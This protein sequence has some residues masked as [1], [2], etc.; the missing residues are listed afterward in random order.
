MTEPKTILVDKTTFYWS[1]AVV[2]VF[3]AGAF[4]GG[5]EFVK[6]KAIADLDVPGNIRVLK[7]DIDQL[8]TNSQTTLA[9]IKSM[10]R[11]IGMNERAA[12][13][14]EPI[15][16]VLPATAPRPGLQR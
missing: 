5:G 14:A 9:E 7:A 13:D 12:I 4:W 16:T 8:K 2:A 1:T 3:V 11:W 10:K 15:P 6:W